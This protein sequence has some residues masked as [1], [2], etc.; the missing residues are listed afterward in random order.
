MKSHI[1][2]SK[3]SDQGLPEFPPFKPGS[4]WL[5]GAGPGDPGLLSLLAY[6]ALG[7]ADDI[8]YDA[9]VGKDVLA[10]ASP[11]AKLHGAGKRGGRPSAKQADITHKLVK[12]ATSG[13]KVLRLKGG[14]PF[15]FGRGS[16]E[17]LALSL[18]QIPF[19]LVP[20]ITAAVAGL[21]SAGIPLTDRWVNSAV[22]FITGHE[23][24]GG[25]PNNLNWNA[26]ASSA[27]V[28]VLY[29]SLNHLPNMTQ[30]LITAGLSDSPP[31]N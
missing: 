4:V 2:D 19:R 24:G 11:K 31:T 9:L 15:V 29:K 23:A 10:L 27:S 5:V 28:L 26:L 17:A 14:D 25:P 8:V 20:G 7:Q 13:R 12:L 30:Q 18:E 21:A 22:T 16:E 1:F 6:Y 3:C